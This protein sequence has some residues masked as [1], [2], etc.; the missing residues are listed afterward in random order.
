MGRDKAFV[1][2]DGVALWRRQLQLLE[3]L[4]PHEVFIAGPAHEEWQEMNCI[5][6]PDAEPNSGPLAGIVGCLQRC[7]RPLLLVIAI[8]LP[9]MTTRYLRELVDS[10]AADRGVLPSHGERSEP[11]AAVYP[12]GSLSLAEKCLAARELSVQR[13]AARCVAEGLAIEKEI[14]PGDR[15]LFLN[16]NTP[17]DLAL[18][19]AGAS[20]E[21]HKGSQS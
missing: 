1:E 15:T 19:E 20:H 2:F 8:D 10:C 5:I 21:G 13:F 11:L 3:E 4:R 7:A 18:A 17:D 16:M 12:K 9:N 6:I 14:T